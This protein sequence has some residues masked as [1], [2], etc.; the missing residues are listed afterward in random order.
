MLDRRVR[1]EWEADGGTDL[2]ARCH[3]K[4]KD[5]LAEY[6]PEPLPD[7]VAKRISRAVEGP[8]APRAH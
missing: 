7:D 1:E 2:Y 6:H 4:A 5:M 8:T 3:A